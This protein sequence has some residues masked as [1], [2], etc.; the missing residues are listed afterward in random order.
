MRRIPVSAG[1]LVLSTRYPEE[2]EVA[3]SEGRLVRKS[4]T[5]YCGNGYGRIGHFYRN[6][7]KPTP[8]QHQQM[9]FRVE[10]SGH[11]GNYYFNERGDLFARG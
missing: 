1:R 3:L 5:K 10:S 4:E 11:L 9:R 2:L 6:E 7:V 8:D